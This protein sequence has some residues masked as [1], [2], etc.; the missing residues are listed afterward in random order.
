MK[1]KV[2]EFT[3]LLTAHTDDRMD[4]GRV[5]EG[6]LG[7]EHDWEEHEVR[8]ED[9]WEYIGGVMTSATSAEAMGISRGTAP[10]QTRARERAKAM[11]R[12]RDTRAAARDPKENRREEEAK[13]KEAK[14]GRFCR[15]D[16]AQLRSWDWGRLSRLEGEC[17]IG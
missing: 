3:N 5:Q 17:G 10:P 1:R 16:R 12:E 7:H 2:M 4:L 8:T 9:E 14:E 11:A 15:S 13:D 6:G